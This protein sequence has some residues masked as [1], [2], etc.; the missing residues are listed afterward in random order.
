MFDTTA[1]NYFTLTGKLDL[2]GG[3]H[4]NT[5]EAAVLTRCANH[6][7]TAIIDESHARDIARGEGI[8][9]HGSLWLIQRGAR[10]NLLTHS[11]ALALI[12]ELRFAGMYLPKDSAGLI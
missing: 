2:G 5:G 4:K 9:V 10:L 3:R 8:D 12:D 1:L 7:G 11:A 6:G